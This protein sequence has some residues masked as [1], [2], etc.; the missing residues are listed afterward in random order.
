MK[1]KLTPFVCFTLALFW[2]C[3]QART[4]NS[5]FTYQGRLDNGGVPTSGLYDF[6]FRL[7]S[8]PFANNY[9]DGSVLTN[10]VP[11][12]NGLFTVT[13][14]FGATV[15]NGSNYWLEVDVRTNGGGLYA[16]LNPLQPLTPAPY[17]LFANAANT[18]SNLTGALPSS[19][20]SGAYGNAVTLSNPSNSFS[21]S[22]AGD[23]GSLTNITATTVGGLAPAAIWNLNGN[24]VAP[25]QFLG[26][27]N[28]QPLELR[29]NGLRGLQLIASPN[30][31]FQSNVINVINGS[32]ANFVAPGVTAA[33]IGGGGAQFYG[34]AIPSNSIASSI[35]TVAGGVGN[36]IQLN[37]SVATI[38]GGQLNTIQS[39][40]FNTT[41]A[42]GYGNVIGSAYATIGGGAY[43]TVG[44][45]SNSGTISGGYNHTIGN[46]SFDGAIGGGSYH[47][48]GTN[49]YYAT[50][51][52]GRINTIGDNSTSAT[53]A[54][55]QQNAIQANSS[56]A[57]VGG[58]F[59]NTL[60]INSQGA[61]IGGGYYN[62]IQPNSA[63][64]VVGGGNLNI[65]QTNSFESTIGGGNQNTIYTN[66]DT[67]TISGGQGNQIGPRANLAIISG[68]GGNTIQ[69]DAGGSGI[70]GGEN[71][72]VQ[73]NVFASIIGGGYYNSIQTNSSYSVIGGGS[74]NTNQPNAGTSFIG[75]GY[76]NVVGGSLSVIA[77]GGNNT[78]TPGGSANAI[79]GGT[80]N[81]SGGFYSTV[82]GGYKNT[83]LGQYSFAAGQNALAPGNGS[84]VWNS[85]SNPNYAVGDNEFFVFAQNGFSVDYSTQQIDGGGSRW[86]YIG[87]GSGFSG[88]Q[89]I[90]TWTGGYLSDTGVWQSVSDRNRKTDFAPITAQE[91]LDKVA[92]L[93]LQSWRYTNEMAG[94]K[95]IGPTA[96]D[97]HAAF[98]LGTDDKTIGA[99][100]EG[101]VAL[102]AIQGLNQKVDE[103]KTELNHRDTEN[104]ELKQRLEALE[105]LVRNQK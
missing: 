88:S 16:T 49:S 96:Q 104:A 44:T 58:G 77:G 87:N 34:G 52:G 5:A 60:Q 66:S 83:A 73:S 55:G 48:I 24:V 18:A 94:V 4:Q 40:S 91:V 84:F 7:A 47:T 50:I 54:G 62:T 10:G 57:A 51:A 86:V 95:H 56:Y 2:L 23:G 85:Y 70:V 97:F 9:V 100:D 41:I 53:I 30:G 65:I 35:G 21:G 27:T 81:T 33:T 28:N 11:V 14:D 32:P 102:A 1:P 69:I 15:F 105:R 93:P 82:P 71:N 17:A 80:F 72:S 68:G 22:Y 74:N 92:G 67:S 63:Y 101:G 43:H 98:A 13:I 89:T 59:N 103:L 29:V 90:S 20:L 25:G 19:L 12:T 75:G 39:N 61:V 36:T 8:D 99:V 37:A 3:P 6:R 31:A 79:G 78:I 76:N 42:G 26:S 64:S 45:N 38:G 46:N